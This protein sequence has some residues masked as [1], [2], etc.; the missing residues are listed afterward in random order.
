MSYRTAIEDRPGSAPP[1][2]KPVGPD[3]SELRHEPHS[4]VYNAEAS[5][6]NS[7][8]PGTI[9]HEEC[10]IRQER[11]RAW[12]ERVKSTPATPQGNRTRTLG[13]SAPAELL[14]HSKHEYTRPQ[15][16]G[17]PIT[18]ACGGDIWNGDCPIVQ[19]LDWM[20]RAGRDSVQSIEA[21]IE[22]MEGEPSPMVVE[23]TGPNPDYDPAAD[24]LADSAL[25]FTFHED[26]LVR[27]W[28]E[29][30]AGDI[31]GSIAKVREYGGY[32]LEHTGL[33]VV[34]LAGKRPRGYSKAQLQKLGCWFYINGKVGRAM[35][36]LAE[37]REPSPDTIFDICYYTMMLRRIDA[38]G[39]WPGRP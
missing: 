7:W 38:V 5:V 6:V 23:A 31:E 28:K 14:R 36:A 37:G 9:P 18:L 29:T 1:A 4:Y 32:D 13:F 27:W 20:Y 12:G 39:G 34:L 16:H 19:Q 21:T 25:P 26:D 8:C 35:S 15:T 24:P 3:L 2:T 11:I 10:P 22:S 33:G 30:A 17:E